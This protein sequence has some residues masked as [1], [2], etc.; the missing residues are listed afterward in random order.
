MGLAGKGRYAGVVGRRALFSLLVVTGCFDEA[1]PQDSAADTTTSGAV[2]TD[3][4]GS[5]ATGS[6]D[7]TGTSTSG[8][9]ATSTGADSTGD[10]DPFCGDGNVDEGEACDDGDDTVVTDGCHQCMVSGTVVWESFAG[11]PGD[12]DL[13]VELATDDRG[14]IYAAGATG[15]ANGSEMWLR[16]FEPDGTV[17]WTREPFPS[18]N[19]GADIL[20]GLTISGQSIIV[21]GQ[22]RVDGE[23]LNRALVSYDDSGGVQFAAY[24]DNPT[25]PME[26]NGALDVAVDADGEIITVGYR[27]VAFLDADAVVVRHGADGVP[28]GDE[29]V[30]GDAMGEPFAAAW[31][32]AARDGQLRAS[33][34]LNDR[35]EVVAWDGAFGDGTPTWSQPIPGTVASGLQFEVFEPIPIAIEADGS[36]VVCT[37]VD[38]GMS[39][40]DIQIARVDAG[41]NP[42][43]DDTF[44]DLATKD[45]CGSVAVA[46]NG[47]I[48]VAWTAESNANSA[49]FMVTRTTAAGQVVWQTTVEGAVAGYAQGIAIAEDPEGYVIVGGTQYEQAGDRQSYVAKLVP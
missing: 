3:S 42:L 1:Q 47:D 41:G 18:D 21:A 5:T 8:A 13:V 22:E 25:L 16:K 10:P 20:G 31:R 2:T 48:L 24:Y 4:S 28:T 17:A 38:V 34:F 32:I 39:D 29:Y 11:T 26:G 12:R 45:I 36:S 23:Q 40:Q 6:A 7:T 43:N 49:D 35:V 46:A 30:T 14:N 15:E 27:F 9:G 33:M 37:N 19:P 44:G